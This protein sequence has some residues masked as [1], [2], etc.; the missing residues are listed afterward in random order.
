MNLVVS[1]LAMAWLY[2]QKPLQVHSWMTVT[3][4]F[5][6]YVDPNLTALYYDCVMFYLVDFIYLNGMLHH[7]YVHY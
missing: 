3:V 4:E 1:I 7:Y 5:F 6:M 2:A